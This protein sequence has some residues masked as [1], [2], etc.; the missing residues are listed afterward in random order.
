M[1]M[2]NPSMDISMD[3]HIHGKP[4]VAPLSES[5]NRQQQAN[6]SRSIANNQD[7]IYRQLKNRPNAGAPSIKIDSTLLTVIDRST[8]GLLYGLLS[9]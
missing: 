9:K 1:D 6:A 3:I 8:H 5:I 2:T 7:S 4:D